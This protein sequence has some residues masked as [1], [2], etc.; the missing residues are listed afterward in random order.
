[1][2]KVFSMLH[3]RE[4]DAPQIFP[5][6]TTIVTSSL[7]PSTLRPFWEDIYSK[8]EECA[9]QNLKLFR[10]RVDPFYEKSQ[11]NSDRAAAPE[12]H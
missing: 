7:R 10:F 3:I 5:R 12:N 1:M 4:L 8:R 2:S 11:N 6:E 9:L